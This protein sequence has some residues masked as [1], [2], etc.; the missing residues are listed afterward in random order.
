MRKFAFIILGCTWSIFS[1]PFLHAATDRC[2]TE[3]EVVTKIENC[4]SAKNPRS[5]TDYVC[6]KGDFDESHSAL[7]PMRIAQYV[8][9]SVKVQKVD[10]K[11]L[12]LMKQY[13]NMRSPSD[14]SWLE[15][16]AKQLGNIE[17][18]YRSICTPWF[19]YPKESISCWAKK[20][21]IAETT[22]ALPATFC[23]D[24]INKKM[25]AWNDMADILALR[26][27]AKWM[28]NAKDQYTGSVKWKYATL[29]EKW[30]SYQRTFSTAV[31]K[32]TAYIKDPIT[33]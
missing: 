1:T 18:E 20:N 32:F 24:L 15:D 9:I 30:S 11:A 22:D 31:Q 28:Q 13:Q 27:K 16:K 21:N 12:A 29:L 25:K 2:S 33:R 6:V 7:T 5:I 8:A 23:G 3:S 4:L 14:T 19:G 10:D 17:K 26:G